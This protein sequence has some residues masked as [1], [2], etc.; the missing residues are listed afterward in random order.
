[1]LLPFYFL[2]PPP[3]LTLAVSV[4]SADWY[5]PLRSTVSKEKQMEC[6]LLFIVFGLCP[7]ISTNRA[8]PIGNFKTKERKG[9]IGPLFSCSVLH[10]YSQLATFLH[11]L[12]PFSCPVS[13]VRPGKETVQQA[14]AFFT[15]RWYTMSVLREQAQARQ[16]QRNVSLFFSRYV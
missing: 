6:L 7:E 5:S 1:M 11:L 10:A 13:F 8:Q 9:V 4:S 16:R 3:P 12:H 15:C 2:P 14:I